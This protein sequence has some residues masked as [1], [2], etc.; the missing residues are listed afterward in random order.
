MRKE[1]EGYENDDIC[2]IS[3]EDKETKAC[4]QVL[5]NLTKMEKYYF[6]AVLI[7]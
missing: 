3:V 5:S 6:M 1:D 2:F 7:R 4:V